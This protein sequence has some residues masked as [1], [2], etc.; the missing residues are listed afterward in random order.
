[1]KKRS[2]RLISL[3][4]TLCL[5]AGLLAG[6]TLPAA[7][8]DATAM[9]R[10]V[11][12]T[13]LAYFYKGGAVQYDSYYLTPGNRNKG[14]I[15]RQTN[16]R[17]PE[18]ATLENPIFT[19]C[20]AFPHDV[21]YSLF[22]HH[23]MTNDTVRSD[24]Q[25]NNSG[26]DVSQFNGVEDPRLN[27]ANGILATTSLYSYYAQQAA[28][29]AKKASKDINTMTQ[30]E[31]NELGYPMVVRYFGP[32]SEDTTLV[33]DITADYVVDLF[34]N[35]LKP[36]DIVVG[37]VG[38]DV[39][40]DSSDSGHAMMFVG[41]VDGDGIGELLHSSGDKYNKSEGPTTVPKVSHISASV[42]NCYTK[43]I[44]GGATLGINKE[45][46]RLDGDPGTYYGIDGTEGTG[47]Y[48]NDGTSVL[49]GFDI[50]EAPMSW[51][52]YNM[53]GKP[54]GSFLGD[55]K[56]GKGGGSGAMVGPAW[57]G[58]H[59]LHTYKDM[60]GGSIRMD[61]WITQCGPYVMFTATGTGKVTDRAC[62]AVSHLAFDTTQDRGGFY[63][64]APV[65][66]DDGTENKT[67]LNKFTV[68][69]PLADPRFASSLL[70]PAGKART[71]LR[72]L[73][74][75][76][77]SAPNVFGSVTPG[78]R[79]TYTVELYNPNAG[80]NGTSGSITSAVVE[81]IPDGT[82]L[83]SASAEQ[84]TVTNDGTT[85][86]WHPGE[87]A[88]GA[89]VSMTY[90]V[91]TAADAAI[92]SSIVSPAGKVAAND[93]TLDTA[94]LSTSSLTHHVGGE[95]VS[96]SFHRNMG[97]TA[98]G[99]GMEVAKA[100]YAQAGI[101][102]ELPAVS[103]L[104][105]MLLT[106]IELPFESVAYKTK[107]RFKNDSVL[108]ENARLLR[109]MIVPDYVGGYRLY[110]MD[111]NDLRTNENRLR[112]Y[113]AK[114]LTPGDILVYGRSRGSHDALM[115]EYGN[116]VYVYLGNDTFAY[117]DENR[118]YKELYDPILDV[119]YANGNRFMYSRILTQCF[120]QDFFCLLRPTQVVQDLN[121]TK[122]LIVPADD[123][124]EKTLGAT[125]R[126]GNG[127]ENRFYGKTALQDALAAAT[128]AGTTAKKPAYINVYC[129]QNIF[130]APV[131][132]L[133]GTVD[134][135]GHTVTCG[136][137]SYLYFGEQTKT[138][139]TKGTVGTKDVVTVQ[140]GTILGQQLAF[141][142]SDSST[143]YL[144]DLVICGGTENTWAPAS[145]CFDGY[146]AIAASN[147]N[148]Y[149]EDCLLATGGKIMP[150]YGTG[151]KYHIIDDVTI[152]DPVEKDKSLCGVS[153]GFVVSDNS[154]NNKATTPL[155]GTDTPAMKV[156]ANEWTIAKMNATSEAAL[157]TRP[158]TVKLALNGGEAQDYTVYHFT[159]SPVAE[160]YATL[161]DIPAD[162]TGDVTLL[163][164]VT[165]PN[166]HEV[167]ADGACTVPAGATL[168]TDT[169]TLTV[170][171]GGTLKGAVTG[172]VAAVG[173]GKWQ[174]DENSVF[175]AP[176]GEEGTVYYDSKLKLDDW[177]LNLD[178]AIRMNL[179]SKETK[180]GYVRMGGDK[181]AGNDGFYPAKAYNAKNMVDSDTASL[182]RQ[183]GKT[184]AGLAIP[185]SVRGYAEKLLGT[186]NWKTE[187]GENG[188]KI[189]RL[190][191]AMLNYGAAAQKQFDYKVEDPATDPVTELL[192]HLEEIPAEKL[193]REDHRSVTD[194]ASLY[195][196]T[197]C[198]LGENMNMK[199]YLK[200]K[201]VDPAAVTAEL[202][203]TD[204][205][206]TKHTEPA[207]LTDAGNGYLACKLTSLVAAD[208]D[209]EVTLKISVGGEVKTTVTDS[210]S[211]YLARIKSDT[212]EN[213]SATADAMMLF[214]VAAKEYFDKGAP[215]LNDDELPVG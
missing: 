212:T 3:L 124:E 185:V 57:N 93:S 117:Y 90:T 207:Q 182:V 83:V 20:S 44:S 195:Y 80:F 179:I 188:A 67:K 76:K 202:S 126:F 37:M 113:Y 95:T 108:T 135:G 201:T 106:G 107:L 189:G 162:A 7:A 186:V 9:Q 8:E 43:D 12:D 104:G 88:D 79:I 72:D 14:A 156:K 42:L 6:I 59:P 147:S 47:V 84:G 121:T 197:S 152:L 86:T 89:T 73:R 105:S 85:V 49:R 153:G 133:F 62:T 211:S 203:Y 68:L 15:L 115:E 196:G 127:P 56:N 46:A 18:D 34:Q 209:T 198:V 176:E 24:A 13:A 33:G 2:T 170:A 65:T 103:E 163:R 149:F 128:E 166:K 40:D 69:R 36:G 204:Y 114:F 146:S 63:P 81:T 35:V 194:D 52:R 160:G 53:N 96:G 92:G 157:Y 29:A 206:G 50:V 131:N 30:A 91:Q 134:L 70:T 143:A 94:Y 181:F 171:D 215:A 25:L 101:D 177:S 32:S 151:S 178:D 64:G 97:V 55:K 150:L 141:Y 21:Y 102:L 54:T 71:E 75:T 45:A 130:G 214:G 184:Y 5:T 132:K 60:G 119:Q 172:T 118:N 173:S 210:I 27:Y 161:C 165:L 168:K 148:I 158:T 78:G 139:T 140:N 112:M 1:M 167:S 66:R 116:K 110:T 17:D 111:G 180:D 100:V 22:H 190:M 142:T 169:Y 200:C 144:K 11:V 82:T 99:T 129:D 38:E 175:A 154:A 164:D 61:D 4:L 98:T 122:T 39:E 136:S 125:L 138:D 87:I 109:D 120:L 159:N 145:I 23:I 187:E 191:L 192:P 213:V 19:V 51:W 155:P 183:D 77:T 58:E 31:K 26:I 16:N 28:V 41:D 199:F 74:V 48:S 174:P 123:P 208:I 10:L 193:I 137:K 205:R